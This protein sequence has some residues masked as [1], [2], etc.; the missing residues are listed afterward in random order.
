[1]S[2][3]LSTLVAAL[4]GAR[5]IGEGAVA[6]ERIT[7][8]SRQVGPGTLFV[9]VRGTR[10]DGHDFLDAAAAAGA[11]AV[12]CRPG[13][14]SPAH[15]PRV[16]VEDTALAL[17]R[18]AAALVGDPTRRVPV[19][20]VTGTNGKT[21]CTFL[22]EAMLRAAGGDPVALGTVGIRHGAWSQSATH[23]TPDAVSLATLLA[24]RVDAGATHVVMEVSSHALDQRRVDGLR[25]DVAVFT[26]LSRDHLDY[27]PG[28]DAYFEAKA[29]LFR[30]LLPAG[31]K[32]DT[33]AIVNAEDAYGARLLR[34]LTG[35]DRV[36]RYGLNASAGWEIYPRRVHL[37]P[38][39]IHA[40]VVTPVGE[41]EI[42]SSLVGRH[43]L[44]N[45]LASIGGVVALG[46]PLDAVARGLRALPGVPGRL[47][48]VPNTLGLTVFVDYAHTP[49]ALERVVHELRQVCAGRLITVFGCGGDRD[50]GKRPLMAE[51]A[52]TASDLV[53]VTSDNPRSEDPASIV[54][55]TVS[56]F[57]ETARAYPDIEAYRREGRRGWVAEIDRRAAI[58]HAVELAGVLDVV[59]VA[60]KGHEATQQ[61]GAHRH[62]FDDREVAAAALQARAEV[63]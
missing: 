14:A 45:L 48:R 35:P 30:E 26:N 53:V 29:R 5:L 41:V 24:E 61:I 12:V 15:L 47:E 51:A 58:G 2:L 39:G 49:D 21:T 46:V 22:V 40:F 20:G 3:P 54:A 57:P 33:A 34:D 4:P 10:S 16:E 9:A 59:L 44:A 27:H 37:G 62:P 1:M 11:S 60:G 18:F 56:G 63:A 28:M 38:E 25:F 6:I 55:D 19:V 36:W 8:D 7:A 50:R 31:G 32:A 52:Y 42:Q 13:S 17:A 23:T 43:N